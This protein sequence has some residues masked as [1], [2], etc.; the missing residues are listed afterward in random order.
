MSEVNPENL[1]QFDFATGKTLADILIGDILSDVPKDSPLII[2]PDGSLGAL[3]FEMLVLNAGGEVKQDKEIPYTSGA[4]FFGARNHISYYQSM[5][6]LTLARTLGKKL[7]P[8]EKTLAIVDP[9][10]RV[11]DARYSKADSEKR[12]AAREKVTHI[13]LMSFQ[14][15][16]GLELRRLPLTGRLGESL[17]KADSARTDLYQGLTAQKSVLLNN[18]L[19]AYRSCVFGT[20]GYFG[21]ELPGI[22]EPVLILTLLD[23]PPGQDGFLRM[24]EVMGLNL[25]CEV[26]ALTACQSGLGRTISGEGTMGMGRAFQ[27]AGAKSLCS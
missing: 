19:T 13:E 2:V 26:A 1:A 24:T 14:P 23:Q 20:H 4:E 7:K 22:K 3:S 6:A 25:N 12:Q 21:A 27:Y 10:F 17:K 15:G 8:A 11:D 18:D 9:I 16:I 5:T